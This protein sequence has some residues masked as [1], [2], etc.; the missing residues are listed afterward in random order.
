MGLQEQTQ[1]FSLVVLLAIVCFCVLLIAV[2]LAIGLIFLLIRLKVFEGV[3][4]EIRMSNIVLILILTSAVM[5]WALVLLLGKIP[6]KPINKLVNGLNSLA[7]GNFKTRISYKGPLGNHPTF[8]EITE[9][10]NKLAKELESTEM[11]R[12][13]FINNFSHE[14]KTPIVSIAGFAKL[15]KKGNLSE[16]QK[17]QYLD[18][19]EE[20][21]MRLSYMATNILNM[22]KIEN[23]EILTDITEFNLSEQVRFAVLL[24]EE[25]WTKKRIEL[26][27]DFEEYMIE[28]NEELLKQVWINLIDNAVKFASASATVA[29]DIKDTEKTFLISV[30]NTG[31]DIPKEKQ[32][33]IFHKFYQAD[34]SHAQE[35]NGIG[36]AIVKKIADLHN[37]KVSFQSENGLT[38]FTVELPKKQRS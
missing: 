16:E 29:L 25:K 13:D 8:H 26:Q 32:K 5:G 6:L 22:T 34:E 12:S 9:S 10:F 14:F 28:A 35:G 1:R 33:N 18:A 36:L 7:T 30:S 4:Q 3:P 21:S 38:V 20:E 2:L 31:T 17:I 19:I 24:L 27:L 37:G 23:Q 15:L 11:L